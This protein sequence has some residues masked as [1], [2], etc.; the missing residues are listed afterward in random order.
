MKL[1]VITKH[2]ACQVGVVERQN[3]PHTGELVCVD[4]NCTAKRK[5]IKWLSK[6]EQQAITNIN[7]IN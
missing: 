6:T 7:D 3:S 2:E 4:T 1:N 5:H